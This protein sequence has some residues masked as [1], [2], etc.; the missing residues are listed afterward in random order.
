LGTQVLYNT[1]LEEIYQGHEKVLESENK[2]KHREARDFFP[3][4]IIY[5]HLAI[6]EPAMRISLHSA[7]IAGEQ[8][9]SRMDTEVGK[10]VASTPSLASDGDLIIWQRP[11]KRS[12]VSRKKQ[13][14]RQRSPP[15]DTAGKRC[16]PL[17]I[18]YRA[19]CIWTRWF[20][21]KAIYM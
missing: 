5:N 6:R 9:V 14:K 8:S 19:Q 3:P 4:S 17:V 2:E 12:T 18:S 7:W 15:Y 20:N 11:R 21:S 10:F 1:H 16:S 13:Q